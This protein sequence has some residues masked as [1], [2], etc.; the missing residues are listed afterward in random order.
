MDSSPTQAIIF[1]LDG[2]LLDT[3]D[4]LAFITNTVLENN[5]FPTHPLNAYRYFVGEGTETLIRNALGESRADEKN[6]L[7]CLEEFLTIYRNTCGEKA[8][9]YQGIPQL[10]S[11][12][13]CRGLKLAV[14]S[15]K[16]HDLTLKN[17]DLFLPHVPFGLVLGQRKEIPK[18][19]DP[20]GVFEILAHLKVRPEQCLYLGDTS[21][22]MKTA[23]AAGTNPVGVLWGFR[24]EEE[25]RSSGGRCLI[26][27]P[28]DLIPLL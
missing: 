9:L 3:L 10:L 2:T 22:D 17:I 1:D 16:P 27:H 28:M 8:R 14:L 20:H 11:D 5:G 19:P 25:L 21:I 6:V 7:R 12:L 15:N 4:E 24:G 18:K 23:V 13:V 26:R